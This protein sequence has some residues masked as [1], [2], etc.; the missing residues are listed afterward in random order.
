MADWYRR[1]WQDVIAEL[2]TDAASGLSEEEARRRLEEYRPN[3]L[4]R[5][6]RQDPWRILWE[7]VYR[8][9]DHH[10]DHLGGDIH[11]PGESPT[12]S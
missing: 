1:N 6:R 12:R 9:L 7:T 8:H 10:S 2:K 4:K 3:E 11:F 5:K